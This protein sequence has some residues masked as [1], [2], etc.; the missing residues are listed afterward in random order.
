MTLLLVADHDN[1][2][3]HDA[4]ARA[5]TAALQIDADVHVLVAGAGAGGAAAAAAGL[6]GVAKVLHA[7]APALKAPLAEALAALIVALAPGYGAIVA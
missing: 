1:A 6:A 2:T 4:T 3:L 7:E 5:L